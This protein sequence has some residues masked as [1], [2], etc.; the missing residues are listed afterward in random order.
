MNDQRQQSI[1]KFVVVFILGMAVASAVIF[2]QI[3]GQYEARKQETK[4]T[5]APSG[6]QD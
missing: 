4:K 2:A 6:G 3:K 1:G 5:E